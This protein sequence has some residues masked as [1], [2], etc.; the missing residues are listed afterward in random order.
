MAMYKKMS[1]GMKKKSTFQR[2]LK[3]TGL[4]NDESKLSVAEKQKLMTKRAKQSA[5]YQQ[6]AQATNRKRKTY[7]LKKPKKKKY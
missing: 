2:K 6:Q 5:K 4:V 1:K 7:S 3:K